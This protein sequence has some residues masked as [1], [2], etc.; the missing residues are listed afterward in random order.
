MSYVPRMRW[1]PAF[2]VASVFV[3]GSAVAAEDVETLAK[4]LNEEHAA[5]S[6]QDC[7]TACKALASIRRAADK[8]CVLEPGA[9]CADA[10]AKADDAQRRVQAACPDCQVA[11]APPKDDERRVVQTSTTP[12]EPANAPRTEKRGGCASCHVAGEAETGDLGVL[13]LAALVCYSLRRASGRSSDRR[14]GDVRIRERDRR[15]RRRR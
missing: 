13:M 8:I 11:A 5:L 7:V 4:Q 2:V 3:T 15:R 9:R 1:G 6:T 12:A 10:R 14:G